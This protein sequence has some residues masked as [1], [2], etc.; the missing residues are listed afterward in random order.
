MIF[1]SKLI[2]NAETCLKLLDYE[3]QYC[4]L[5]KIQQADRTD[6]YK[7]HRNIDQYKSRRNIG[8]YKSHSNID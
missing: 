5:V 6:Q 4:T 8:Q 1:S 2:P 7:S 3:I